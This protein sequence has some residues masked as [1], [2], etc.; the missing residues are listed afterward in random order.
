MSESHRGEGPE[1]S[2]QNCQE[3]K[4][5][6]VQTSVFINILYFLWWK[7]KETALWYYISAVTFAEDRLECE[8]S[9]LI[10]S[11]FNFCSYK[12]LFFRSSP[13]SATTVCSL[14]SLCRSANPA[15]QGGDLSCLPGDLATTSSNLIGHKPVSPLH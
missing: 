2:L 15:A 8:S 14:W 12:S 1:C 9:K 5:S 4:Y 11:Y 3:N 7:H 13:L 6:S 10:R